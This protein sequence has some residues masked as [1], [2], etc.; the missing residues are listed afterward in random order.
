MIPS[1]GPVN[2]VVYELRRL[3]VNAEGFP[4]FTTR[5]LAAKLSRSIKQDFTFVYIGWSRHRVITPIVLSRASPLLH[6]LKTVQ[7]WS[8]SSLSRR[9]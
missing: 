5:A 3:G 1:S 9:A 4:G 6:R 7:S 8:A 2:R